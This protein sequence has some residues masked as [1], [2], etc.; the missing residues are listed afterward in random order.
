[1]EKNSM[2]KKIFI[3]T[4]LFLF[5][6]IL[7]AQV[8][9]DQC[10]AEDALGRKSLTYEEVGSKKTDKFIGMFYWTWHTDGIAEWVMPNGSIA[11]ITEI[12]ANNHEGMIMGFPDQYSCD[13][14]R[15]LEPVKAW[16]DKGDVYYLQFVNNVRKFEG[17][18][19]PKKVSESKTISMN[20]INDWDNVL[21]EYNHYEGNTENRNH[22]GQGPILTY[23]NST[24]RNDIVKAI[25]ARDTENIYFYIEAADGLTD[26]TDANW[27]RLYID[28]DRDKSTGWEGY[29][30]I[31]NRESPTDS[32]SVEKSSNSWNW[33]KVGSAAYMVTDNVLEIKVS[34][35]II[36][37]SSDTLNFE[38]K[39]SDNSITDGNIMDFYVNGDVA[40]GGR[41]NFVY[42]TT[43]I[44]GVNKTKNIPQR[45][46]LEQNYPNPFNPSTIIRYEIGN[47]RFTTLE[48]FNVLG[49]KVATLVNELQTEGSYEVVFDAENFLSG[50]YFLKL[51]SSDLQRQKSF[52]F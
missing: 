11:N 7:F 22:K 21:P 13:K 15:D 2:L 1:M 8:N 18:K 35:E 12:V 40:P 36:S 42:N 4:I 6:Q 23:T 51:E 25:I 27:M 24:G 29:D 10:S 30:Y 52:Y 47:Q 28:I 17:M 46:L 31:L 9:I 38:F 49:K 20:N 33:K 3:V 26:N 43:V 16:G 37:S 48:I 32:I 5:S 45:F 34:R 14:S 19:A 44:N 50:T 41:F 39:W